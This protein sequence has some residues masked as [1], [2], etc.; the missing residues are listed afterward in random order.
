[1]PGMSSP[2]TSMT[3]EPCP[4]SISRTSDGALRARAVPRPGQVDR[5]LAGVPD[6]PGYVRVDKR[7]TRAGPP[8]T[9]QS[10]LDVLDAQ[11]LPQ[12]RIALQIDLTNCQVI[13]GTRPCV[14]PSQVGVVGL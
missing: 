10:G 6:Q 4:L 8:V 3:S 2:S 9:Q 5:L 11:R 1:M 14:K 13:R 7:Q 12:Q